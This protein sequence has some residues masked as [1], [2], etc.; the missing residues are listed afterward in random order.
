[1]VAMKKPTIP[2]L[3]KLDSLGGGFATLG[4]I[5]L[6]APERKPTEV[7]DV[8]MVEEKKQVVTGLKLGLGLGKEKM[9]IVTSSVEE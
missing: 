7:K 5:G 3:G 1:M 8:E 4:N 9:A 6:N 2:S